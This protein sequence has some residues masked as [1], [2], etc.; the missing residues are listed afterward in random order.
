MCAEIRQS[1]AV[2][3]DNAVNQ[4]DTTADVTLYKAGGAADKSLDIYIIRVKHEPYHGLD[5]INLKTVQYI[6]QNCV[7]RRFH[8]ISAPF[9]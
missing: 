7:P 8:F 2:C 5:V 6:S 9:T 3:V 1:L 4:P